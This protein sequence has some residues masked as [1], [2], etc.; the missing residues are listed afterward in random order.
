MVPFESSDV[1]KI[2]LGLTLF[3]VLFIVIGVLCLFDKGFIAIGNILF[4]SGVTLTIGVKPTIQFF[5]KP[6]NYKGSV[7]F[8]VGFFFVIIGWPIF[9]MLVETYGFIALFSGFWPTI[10]V[11]VSRIPI[12]GWIFSQ[13]VVISFFERGRPKRVPV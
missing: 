2:G 12:V 4:L 6:R 8:G 1:K 5:T 7:S 9:G 11:S 10:A 3:G 13:P